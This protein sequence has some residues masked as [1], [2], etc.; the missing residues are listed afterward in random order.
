MTAVYPG[1]PEPLDF[2]D[3]GERGVYLVTVE[4]RSEVSTRFVPM[5]L[6]QVHSHDLDITGL[7]TVE[8]VRNA[9]L[10]AGEES[11]R[12]RDLWALR[13]TG[14]VEPE[15]IF[16]IPALERELETTSF[17]AP[18]PRLL[19]G[20]RLRGIGR[21]GKPVPGGPVREARLGL[22]D[23]L[24]NRGEARSASV[25]NL[26]LYYGLDALR[27]GKVI[28]GGGGRDEDQDSLRRRLASSTP[29]RP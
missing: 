3:K 21:S 27:Q 29:P 9:I 19:A 13:L 16:D 24:A 2:G 25:A 10:S 4:G 22:R 17:P 26:A 23:D 11:T 18:N 14:V 15:I 20:I 7:D 6:R 8:R 1:C 28:L 5:A 12:K